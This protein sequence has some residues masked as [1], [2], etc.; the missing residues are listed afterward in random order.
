[1]VTDLFSQLKCEITKKVIRIAI[2]AALKAATMGM[3]FW[4]PNIPDFEEFSDPGLRERMVDKYLGKW[5]NGLW[6]DYKDAE[7][8]REKMVSLSLP[9]YSKLQCEKS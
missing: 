9:H 4:Q 8:F 2:E 7:R 5:K 3:N 1:M 6:L